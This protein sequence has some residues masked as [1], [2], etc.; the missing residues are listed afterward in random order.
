M[1]KI[2]IIGGG[3]AG[4]SAGI[5]AAMHGFSPEILEMHHTS[6]GQCTAWE[7][8]KY[9]FDYCLHWLVGTSSGPFYDIWRETNVINDTTTIIDHEIHSKLHDSE[10]NE[11]IIY[12]DIKSWEEYLL[13]IAPE[14]EKAIR[15][16]CNDMR[17]S[18]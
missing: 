18:A 17:K 9:R 11:F 4:L 6:G 5:Y 2:V 14:D 16:M 7:R 13:N 3:V 12:S 15:S 1:K 8:K 10:G